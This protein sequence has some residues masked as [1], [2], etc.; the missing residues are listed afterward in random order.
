MM[1]IIGFSFPVDGDIKVALGIW[2]IML[3]KGTSVEIW[4]STKI[5]IQICKNIF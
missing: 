3:K 5:R 1:K 2:L 4:F